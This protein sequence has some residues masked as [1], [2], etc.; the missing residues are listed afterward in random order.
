MRS[1]VSKI[2][3]VLV[4]VLIGC[5][6]T[7][8]NEEPLV[9]ATAIS[10]D[11][12]SPT[13]IVAVTPEPAV[14]APQVTIKTATPRPTSDAPAPTVPVPTLTPTPGLVWSLEI[15][16][17]GS[18][19]PI[20]A[21]RIGQGEVKVVV[22]VDDHV[23]GERLI[24]RF[25]AEPRAV[26]EYVSLWI[27][28]ELDPDDVG[29]LTDADSRGDECA[30]NNGNQRAFG[31][32]ESRALRGFAQN[33]LMTLFFQSTSGFPQI[34]VDTCEQDAAT[35]RL[36]QVLEEE[37][38]LSV[39][40]LR[41][42]E[43]H[44]VDFLVGEG[45]PSVLVN[46]GES[47]DLEVVFGGLEAVLGD[48]VGIATEEVGRSEGEAVYFN[49]ANTG[50]R[51]F[52]TGT[53][54]HP[55]AYEFD[56]LSGIAFALDG[57]RILAWPPN[58]DV[59]NVILR[60]GDSIGEVPVLEPMDLVIADRRLLVLDRAGDLY[61]YDIGSGVWAVDRYDRPIRDVSSHYFVALAHDGVATT[62]LEASYN[63]AFRTGQN[64]QQWVLPDLLKVDI[65]S[66]SEEA[67]YLLLQ[68]NDS[69]RGVLERYFGNGGKDRGFRPSIDIV[70]PR[71][72]RVTKQAVYVLD[73]DGRRLLSFGLEKGEL[74]ASYQFA[75]RIGVSTF[76]INRRGETDSLRLLGR[77]VLFTY[78]DTSYRLIDSRA[79]ALTGLQ[80][81][82]PTL[83][84]QLSDFT[85]PIGFPNFVQRDYQMAGAPRHYRLGVHEG[86]DFYW[87]RNSPVKAA[88]DGIVIRADWDYSEPYPEL[89]AYWSGV[90]F[91]NRYTPPEAADFFRGRQVWIDHG[92]GIVTRYVHLAEIDI[93]IQEGQAVSQGQV[94]G[95]VGNSGSPG[96]LEGEN[97][98]SH[99]HFELRVG[100]GYIGQYI[101]PIE[102]R[103]W[104]R[105]I[106]R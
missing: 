45:V 67:T 19:V 92:G 24:Q 15:G 6:G 57:G 1:I 41:E 46:L 79:V 96:S 64:Q 18:G 101:R 74:L 86:F 50:V 98:D 48:S 30:F 51:E 53:F 54:L 5:Q 103:A 20:M 91:Q 68:E 102:A 21:E 39:A 59:P 16:R 36:G 34:N 10:F 32:A 82:D 69:S 8:G 35:W 89:F 11:I 81:H 13:P 93:S 62:F 78:L 84:A 4:V 80:P 105:E 95:Y 58:K 7:I 99:L 100:E 94:I 14:F 22:A 56:P 12:I 42:V 85:I 71:Q 65:D 9:D 43:G 23:V 44:F 61:G 52:T 55:L 27:V 25:R 90:V 77:D 87:Q 75:D 49:G 3:L 29:V 31:S 72:V 37:T 26:P 106:L 60:S 40:R 97:E 63:L 47:F 83:L 73:R 88:A 76:W 2:W 33:A 17:S 104:I 66:I 28:P 70:E 38:G